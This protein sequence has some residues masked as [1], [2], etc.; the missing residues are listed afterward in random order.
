M[1]IVSLLILLLILFVSVNSAQIYKDESLPVEK[2]VEDLLSKMTLEEKIGQMQ[3]LTLRHLNNDVLEKVAAGKVGSFLNAG[4]IEEKAELQ[5]A[6]I[7]KSRLGIPLIFGRDV[8]HGYKTIFPIPLGQAASWNPELI[9]KAASAAAAEAYE[10]GIDWTFAP[11][12]DVTREPRW[13]RIAESGGEDPF[14]ASKISAAMVKGFQGAN[15]TDDYTIAACVKH[16]AGYGAAEAG[17]DY[18]TT[19]IPERLLR[20]V[21]LPSYKAGADAGAATFMSAF[22]EINGIPA[23]GNKFILKKIL[24]EEWGFDGFVVSDW[25]AVVQM[26]DHGFAA[27]TAEA[28]LKAVKAGVNMEMVSTSYTEYLRDHVQNGDLRVEE[29]D[30][31]V[32]GILKV[33]FELGLFEN[34]IHG[35]PEAER[36]LSDGHL[37]TATKLAEESA[38]LLQNEG[39][40]L[41]ISTNIER[42]AVIGPLADAPHDQLGTWIPDGRKEDSV[43]P[44]ESIKKMLPNTEIIFAEGLEEARTNTTEGFADAVNAAGYAD[45]VLMFMGESR[46]MSGEARSRAF[47]DLPGAQEELINAVSVAGKPIVLVIM[48]GR[49]LTFL[50]AAEKVDAILYAWHPG[51]MAGPALANLIFGKAVPSGKLPVTFPRTIGQV[52]IYYAHKNTGRPPTK[53][54]RDIEMGT[55]QNPIGYKSYYLDVDYTPAY[56]FG[57]GLSYTTFEYSDLHLSTDKL[58]IGKSM[59]ASAVVTN[60][61]EIAADEIVQ[62]YVRDLVG[63]VTRPV[64]EL[65]GFKKIHLAAGESHKVTFKIHTDD[66]R[67]YDAGMNFSVEPGKHRLWIAPNSAEGISADFE[68]IASR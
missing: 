57:F 68:I 17:K 40:V 21:Y 58:A 7:K 27:D 18:N 66:L 32:R 53:A 42:L 5:V 38:V 14:L 51:T 44:L 46:D 65:K 59:E 37:A 12:V 19:N 10:A 45:A 62:L 64:K 20:D 1:K 13:G 16:F 63:S 54:M 41:P 36:T 29:I 8:I 33:K 48:A 31:M 9:E 50:K 26:V 47:L 35:D 49:P 22:N 23:T 56:P 39:D 2:R 30:E 15:L 52:P 28:A 43:T 4:G 11:M 67:F 55:P 3:Q 25:D 61:G 34:P 24:R 6:A 60:A